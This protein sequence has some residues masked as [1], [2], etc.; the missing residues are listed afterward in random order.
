MIHALTMPAALFVLLAA[1]LPVPP[2]ARPAAADAELARSL[3]GRIQQ[4][5][6]SAVQDP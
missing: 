6:A 1:F 4:R 5:Q 2:A 3:L